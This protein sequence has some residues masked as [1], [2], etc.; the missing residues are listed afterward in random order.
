MNTSKGCRQSERLEK[1]PWRF[2]DEGGFALI[3]VLGILLLVTLLALGA[4]N[5]SDTDR[6][7]ASN[8][9]HNNQAFYAAEAG[10]NRALGMLYDST[11]RAGFTDAA[12]GHTSYTVVVKDSSDEP[13]LK[14]S[15]ILIATGIADKSES[16]I[17]VL[18]AKKRS[19]VFRR[20]VYG[21]S[22]VDIVGNAL[23]DAYNSDSGAYAPG[24][25]GGDVGSDGLI[26]VGGN[27]DVYGNVTTADTIITNGSMIIHG[28][29][30]NSA[31]TTDL[32]PITQADLDYAKWNSDVST[33]MTLSGGA[34]Y[35]SGTYTLSAS[36]STAQITM[37]SGIYFFS[38]ISLTS[39]AKLVIPAGQE[40][41]IFMTG[42]MNAAGGTIVNT[43]AIPADLQIYSTGP[44]IDITG[45][46]TIYA[47]IY[48]PNAEIKVSGGGTVFGSLVGKSV[49]D[50]G[51]GTVH[52]D[53]ALLDLE[54]PLKA[55]YKAV[56]WQVL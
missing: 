13:G 23:V 22:A 55:K 51:N 36:G 15:L 19:T 10:I 41:I 17:E 35:N 32:E 48:A 44:T 2:Q 54:S 31:S 21:D 30:D 12:I 56:A 47:A 5:T 29:T 27:A 7:I 9:T 18:L 28:T 24:G 20:A 4:F 46:A 14:D 53:R 34:T 45:S 49:K 39:G 37:T 8:N 33:G 43:N 38:S 3:T 50:A 26:H 11:W 52:F 25:M 16:V 1:T 40:V 42:T 6:A